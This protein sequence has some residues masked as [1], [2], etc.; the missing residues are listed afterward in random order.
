MGT[1]HT[2]VGLAVD[3]ANDEARI[4]SLKYRDKRTI[5]VVTH[6]RSGVFLAWSTTEQALSDNEVPAGWWENG[7]KI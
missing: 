7:V 5:A 4:T 1:L 6:D 2:A 3:A